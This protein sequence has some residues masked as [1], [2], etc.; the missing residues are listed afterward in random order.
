MILSKSSSD[1]AVVAWQLTELLDAG[2]RAKFFSDAV[3]RYSK[4]PDDKFKKITW[5]QADD[6]T[7]LKPLLA[8]TFCVED[9][10]LE[11]EILKKHPE[12]FDTQS[13]DE[14]PINGVTLE[15]VTG[16]SEHVSREG[17]SESDAEASKVGLSQPDDY[18]SAALESLE[19]EGVLCESQHEDLD[20]ASFAK[21]SRMKEPELGET[22]ENTSKIAQELDYLYRLNQCQDLIGQIESR[23]AEIPPLW[24]QLSELTVAVASSVVKTSFEKDREALSFFYRGILA[25]SGL[26]DGVPFLL[27]LNP[28]IATW[29]ADEVLALDHIGSLTLRPDPN[30]EIGDI[31]VEYDNLVV[32]RILALDFSEVHKRLQELLMNGD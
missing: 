2:K 4:K 14:L 11:Q 23:L 12:T 15:V 13:S 3:G 25:E 29:F 10:K 17:L 30:L 31:R 26:E 19:A 27:Y 7:S 32:E 1:N 20:D 22:S 28:E 9:V 8:N 5:D 6:V 16:P 24:L 21:S 18:P